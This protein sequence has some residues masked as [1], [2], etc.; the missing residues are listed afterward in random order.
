[1]LSCRCELERW[2]IYALSSFYIL[3][4]FSFLHPWWLITIALFLLL[5]G[6]LNFFMFGVHWALSD[7][8]YMMPFSRWINLGTV[9]FSWHSSV[10]LWQPASSS[11]SLRD[12]EHR[13]RIYC[14]VVTTYGQLSILLRTLPN[15]FVFRNVA[16]WWASVLLASSNFCRIF[17][18]DLERR[19]A[20]FLWPEFER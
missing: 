6:V 1:M 7:Q 12:L 11:E 5:L 3:I 17:H 18:G 19:D 15:S 9:L 13:E 16:G 14:V 10:P 20:V 8:T 2:C 4:S